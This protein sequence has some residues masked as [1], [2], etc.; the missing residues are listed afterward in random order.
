[1]RALVF[2]LAAACSPIGFD[3]SYDVPNLT[4][5]GDPQAHAAGVPF[6]GTAAPFALDVSFDQQEQQSHADGV[7]TVTLTSIDFSITQDSGCF[8][9][10]DD[11]TLTISSTKTG[12]ALAPAVVATGSNPGC[13]QTMTLTPAAIDLK[14]YIDEGAV[15]RA[16]GSGVPPASIVTFDGHV[17]LHAS[18]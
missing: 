9:F 17:V 1:M 11:V 14:P 7:S 12:T 13:V 5:P 3:V 6:S 8:D 10:V 18:L 2:A 15:I 4:I 16:T